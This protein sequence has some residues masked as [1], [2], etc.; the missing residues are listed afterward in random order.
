[1][2]SS[3][4]SLLDKS[5]T[6]TVCV[7]SQVS[8]EEVCRFNSACDQR[9]PKNLMQMTDKFCLLLVLHAFLTGA[10]VVETKC[11]TQILF[12]PM[13]PPQNAPQ[14]E[15]VSKV[16][17]SRWGTPSAGLGFKRLGGCLR[18]LGERSQ[19]SMRRGRTTQTIVQHCAPLNR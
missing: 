17:V 8:A 5:M 1:M 10:V 11:T 3:L 9:P 4:F 18:L 14:R 7:D 13:A 19:K 16:R 6:S 15:W 2:S 12:K